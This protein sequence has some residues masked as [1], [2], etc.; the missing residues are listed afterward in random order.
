M[1]AREKPDNDYVIR[2]FLLYNNT[3]FVPGLRPGL[4][5][6]YFWPMRVFRLTSYFFYE[7][8][9]AAFYVL[10]AFDL[11]SYYLVRPR[12]FFPVFTYMSALRAFCFSL[13]LFSKLPA[14]SS[15]FIFF[16]SSCCH[17]SC[18]GLGYSF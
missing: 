12:L 14:T 11:H 5:K 4:V 10:A 6:I 1:A 15:V 7:I 18:S 8:I 9:F 2:F 13:L 3:S 17:S 16:Y